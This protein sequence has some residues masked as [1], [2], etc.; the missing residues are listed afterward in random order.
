MVGFSRVGLIIFTR[1]VRDVAQAAREQQQSALALLQVHCASLYD[2]ALKRG[3]SVITAADLKDVGPAAEAVVRVVERRLK[4]LPIAPAD[5]KALRDLMGRLHERHA[6]GTSTRT[7]L[8]FRDA[9]RLWKGTAP[10]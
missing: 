6:D 10:L 2:R 8:P 7:L 1:V 9:E 4:D 3:A 5:R